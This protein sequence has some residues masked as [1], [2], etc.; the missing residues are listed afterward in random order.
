MTTIDVEPTIYYTAADALH[1]AASELFGAVQANYAGISGSASMAGSYD[2][3]LVWAKAYDT[4][5]ARNLELA[6]RLAGLL[7]KYAKAL[8]SAGWTH[9]MADY[10]A[11][12]GNKGPAPDRPVNPP[13]A[14]TSCPAP[15]P[16]SG[17][18]GN[19]LSDVVHLAEKVGITI[20]DG[21]TGKLSAVG[22]AWIALQKA[23]AVGGLS[24]EIGRI[25]NS[26]SLVHSPESDTVVADLK[27]MQETAQT[28][29]QG[30]DT[31]AKAS[32][33]QKA[34]LDDLRRKL[35][36]QLEDLAKEIL[37]EIGIGLAITIVTSMVTFGIGALIEAAR[38][39]EIVERF[40]VPIKELV[41]G[42]KNGR[43]LKKA[44]E[45]AEEVEKK[46]KDLEALEQ[47]IGEDKPPTTRNAD[48]NSA[49][50]EDLSTLPA[51]WTSEDTAG[52]KD[53]ISSGTSVNKAVREGNADIDPFAYRVERTNN[54]LRKLPDYKG[55]VK[56]VVDSRDMPPEVL[57]RYQQGQTVTEDA[58]T[59]ASANPA[60]SPF[61][62]DVEMNIY[63][64]TG[65][66]VSKFADP[67]M[68]K[69]EQE[70]LFPTGTQFDVVTRTVDPDTGMT[71]I[72]MI[73]H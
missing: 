29:V 6:V 33:D 72:N 63:S 18:P 65:K 61:S 5:A 42:W 53:Y 15:P 35:E 2:D 7:D 23:P 44:E 64:K 59:S 26:V 70:V 62:G 41:E 60:G 73:E 24:D 57:A 3:A 13:T 9:Q 47:R 58:F 32:H 46:G 69:G 34:A 48:G 1:T 51:G 25:I 16:S 39:A 67:I 38:V 71:I 36:K 50:P 17:G 27:N 49:D 56:R 37:K 10:N 30:F 8:R 11:T 20:P 40:A 12:T 14:V 28:V 19:G 54:A 43:D 22:D 68:Q 55:V 21:D 66:D 52:I 4:N 45:A 31:L